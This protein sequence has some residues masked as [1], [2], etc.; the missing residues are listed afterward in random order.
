MARSV[1][2]RIHERPPKGPS[3][4]QG[5]AAL[6][7]SGCSSAAEAASSRVRKKRERRSKEIEIFSCDVHVTNVDPSVISQPRARSD[8]LS[9]RGY[10][11]RPVRDG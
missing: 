10:G 7:L 5:S 9:R 8:G 3:S 11:G 6:H 4:P 1:V 2:N